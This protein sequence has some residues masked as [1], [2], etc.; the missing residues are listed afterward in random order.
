MPET[1]ACTYTYVALSRKKSPKVCSSLR[2]F[3]LLWEILLSTVKYTAISIPFTLL[4]AIG[5][6]I[7]QVANL[8]DS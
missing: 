3:L 7:L 5:F 4:A 1:R 2:Y 8:S 6:A